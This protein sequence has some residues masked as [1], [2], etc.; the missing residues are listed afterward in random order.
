MSSSYHSQKGAI[1]QIA[2]IPPYHKVEKNGRIQSLE[3]DTALEDLPLQFITCS[4]DGTIA[5][6]DLKLAITT[7]MYLGLSPSTHSVETLKLNNDTVLLSFY[8][9]TQSL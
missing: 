5:F 8:A 1:S 2:W 7:L 3:N 6:W 4:M 9:K